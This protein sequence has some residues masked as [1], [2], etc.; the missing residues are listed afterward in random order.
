[1]GAQ[2]GWGAS[3]IEV[4]MQIRRPCGWKCIVVTGC[5]ALFDLPR[6]IVLAGACCVIHN[7]GARGL[8][9]VRLLAWRGSDRGSA[10]VGCRESE[11]ASAGVG[12][13][14]KSG[15]D[16]VFISARGGGIVAALFSGF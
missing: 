10:S 4:G 15:L 13:P 1:M 9:P 3:G 12:S 16:L 2:R 5:R 11:N 6:Q 7:R 8:V 14:L